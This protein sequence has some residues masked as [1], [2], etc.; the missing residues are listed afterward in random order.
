[1]N[2]KPWLALA[3]LLAGIALAAFGLSGGGT[4]LTAVGL[5]LILAFWFLAWQWITRASKPTAQIK[6]AADAA[7]NLR[8]QPAAAERRDD[9]G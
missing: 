7:W 2:R 9:K 4:L 3:C 6:P 5:G 8:D 1:M